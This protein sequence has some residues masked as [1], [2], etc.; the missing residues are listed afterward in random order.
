VELERFLRFSGIPSLSFTLLKSIDHNVHIPS[1]H[2][3]GSEIATAKKKKKGSEIHLH[4][5][6]TRRY[7]WYVARKPSIIISS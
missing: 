7:L 4:R 2:I 1:R 6:G 5:H 3:K